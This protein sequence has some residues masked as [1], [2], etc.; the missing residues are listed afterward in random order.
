MVDTDLFAKLMFGGSSL[1]CIPY[2]SYIGITIEITSPA[3][4]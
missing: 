1:C 2:W 4:Y 3:G